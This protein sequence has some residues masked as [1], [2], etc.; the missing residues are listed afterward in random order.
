M[1]IFSCML[2]SCNMLD[3]SMAKLFI[4]RVNVA[5]RDVCGCQLNK[6]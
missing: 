2:D 3:G 1:T 5:E 4:C 6:N